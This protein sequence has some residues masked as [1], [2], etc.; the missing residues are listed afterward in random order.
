[1]SSGVRVWDSLFAKPG[2]GGGWVAMCTGM[3]RKP[4]YWGSLQAGSCEWPLKSEGLVRTSHPLLGLCSLRPSSPQPCSPGGVGVVISRG[5]KRGDPLDIP[6]KKY[7]SQD[8]IF[9]AAYSGGIVTTVV[10]V[11]CLPLSVCLSLFLSAS[12]S[13]S[14]SLMCTP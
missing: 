2:V 7:F 8:V 11:P 12:V 4:R 13:V 5:V 10:I 1:M 9:A 3:T 6:R 14:V